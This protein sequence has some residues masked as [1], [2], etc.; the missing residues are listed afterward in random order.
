MSEHTE[1]S[2]YAVLDALS[3]HCAI[4]DN[5][6]TI[7]AVNQ[8]WCR[9]AD[10]HHLLT[11]NYGVGLNYFAVC[12]AAH[13]ADAEHASVVANGIR[14]VMTHQ[15]E[16]FDFE[17]ACHSPQEQCW[18]VVHATCFDSASGVCFL[19]SHENI[20]KWKQA[21]EQLRSLVT[22]TQDAVI[23]IDRLGRITLF[24]PAAERIFGYPHAE[25]FEQNLQMLM[26]EP[27][28]SEHDG[29]VTRY[30]R[31]GERRAIGR[32]RT[33]A[34]KRKNGEVFPIE[35]SVTEIQ[36]GDEVRYGALIRDI[37]EK[38]RLQ[39]QL[40]ERERLAAIGTTAAIFA[41]EVGN[42]LNSMSIAAQLLERQFAKQQEVIDEKSVTT[43]QNLTGEIRRLTQLLG[44]FRVLARR[45]TLDLK[46]ILLT[47]VMADLLAAEAQAYM[48]AGIRVEQFFAP[49]LPVILA[50]AEKLRQVFLNLS[51]NA[52]E[53]MPHGGTLTVRATNVGRRVYVE[54]GD[55]GRGIPPGVN[56]LEPFV[57]TKAQGTGLGLTIA[58]QIVSAHGGTLSYRSDPT[59]GT[60][61]V[62]ELPITI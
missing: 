1:L 19:V 56:I 21:E 7:I 27:Y 26:P 53:A 32:I 13:S 37:S 51:K 15:R 5:T 54:V 59:Q 24:N 4:L 12:E 62:V 41:H 34:A 43:L 22:T 35:L 10:A 50:D 28:A 8:A 17:Y 46:P 25:V 57:T 18:F 33:V 55:T 40:M 42:P 20:T 2:P 29:Y 45:Q 9:F 48:T 39:E 38:V 44:E 31:T 16:E 61:F 49:D 47:T 58:Q 6:G 52:V 23:T 30:E 60:T 36:T 11:P 3:A 14:E